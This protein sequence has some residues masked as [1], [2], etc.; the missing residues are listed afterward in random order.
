MG[1][2][3]EEEISVAIL[4]DK[5][6]AAEKRLEGTA[7]WVDGNN[8]DDKR[9]RWPLVVGDSVSVAHLSLTAYPNYAEPNFTISLIYRT[10]IWRLDYDPPYRYH[11]NPPDRVHLLGAG[12]IWGPHYH[13]WA[14]NRHAAT[15][16]VLPKTLD[17][18]RE[19]PKRIRQWVQAFRWFC[20]ETRITFEPYQLIDFPLREGLL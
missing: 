11:D 2:R 3:Q 19:L 9:I 20:A 5:F 8:S 18:A 7:G 1:P 10:C 13:T 16:A 12:R 17:C 6:L 14:D 15:T 4:V